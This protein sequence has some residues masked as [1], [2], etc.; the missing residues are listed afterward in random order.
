MFRGWIAPGT[1]LAIQPVAA[2]WTRPIERLS[3]A[4]LDHSVSA[5]TK[6]VQVCVLRRP[7]PRSAALGWQPG[8]QAPID[9]RRPGNRCRRGR[10]FAPWSEAILLL[11]HAGRANDAHRR[12][13]TIPVRSARPRQR[14]QVRATLSGFKASTSAVTVKS[15]APIPLRL[16]LDVGSVSESV[17]VSSQ[18]K[19][20]A[21]RGR[22]CRS[23]CSRADWDLGHAAEAAADADEHRGVRPDR[24][25]RVPR[26]P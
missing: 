22:T 2:G 18:R 3:S 11:V 7:V 1:P 21:A 24:R 16:T 5:R 6:G 20:M 15:D 4:R 9:R 25:Q 17:A 23:G 14:I 12:Q 19:E 26:A 13:W 10:E 8:R